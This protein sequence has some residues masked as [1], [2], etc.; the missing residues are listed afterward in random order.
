MLGWTADRSPAICRSLRSCA[1]A[2]N[3]LPVMPKA[4][5]A[6]NLH[7][8]TPSVFDFDNIGSPFAGS[9]HLGPVTLGALASPNQ[10]AT[11]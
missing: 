9:T 10:S 4:G 1:K 7:E 2:H 11:L 8:Y 5:Q 6:Y 3:G